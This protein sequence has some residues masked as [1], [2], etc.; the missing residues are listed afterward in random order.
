MRRRL[1]LLLLLAICGCAPAPQRPGVAAP[2]PVQVPAIARPGGETADWWFVD[3]AAAAAE[4]GA[5]RG[6][7]R[8]VILFVGDGMS[9]TTVAAARVFAG[10]RAGQPGE[11]TRLAFEDLPYT[12]LS[13]TYNTDAQTPDSAGTMTAMITG[14]KTRMGRIAVSQAASRTDCSQEAEALPSLLE[15]AEAAGLSTGIVT[16][17]RIT[18]AT[19]AA[20]YAHV[21]DRNWEDDH[22]VPPAAAAAGCRDIALQL[23]EPRIGDGPEVAL[24]GGR[25]RFLREADVD[26]EYPPWTGLRTDGRNLVAEWRARHPDGTYVTDRA[27]FESARGRPGP[28]LGLFQP[29][30]LQFEH[31]RPRDAAGEPSLAEMT[32]AAIERLSRDPD[33]YVLMVEAGRIDHAHHFGNAFRALSDTVALS[34]AVGAALAAIDRDD[35]LVVVTA[36]HSHTLTFAGYPA[37][38]NPILGTVRG[39]ADEGSEGGALAR[40]ALGLPYTT[41]GYAN[42]PGYA[43]ASNRQPEGPKRFLHDFSAIS[44]LRGDRPDPSTVDTTAPDYLQ[45]TAI[46]LVSETHGGDDVGVWAGGPGAEAFRGSIE[47]NAIFHLMLQST[48]ALRDFACR[49]G[50]CNADGVPVR[51]PLL[52]DLQP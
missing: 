6:R 13:R 2:A 31:D 49:K 43:G 22:M 4:R 3:G 32:V 39:F 14:A 46:P 42:G 10:Q 23:V 38:G 45:D 1:S 12:A 33:G 52:S 16:T 5:P 24:G 11:E 41:L 48:P 37:R 25:L 44:R 47:Q 27:G 9:L 18:H 29:D 30:H 15:I 19:P 36:D 35:T 20:T 8:N 21:P 40:D 51:R 50:R 34:D 26:P 17:T 7:A 28:L